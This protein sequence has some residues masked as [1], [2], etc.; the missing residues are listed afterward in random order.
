LPN[1]LVANVFLRSPVQIR[2]PHFRSDTT[3]HFLV[4]MDQLLG[5]NYPPPF[6]RNRFSLPPFFL[7][8]APPE[9]GRPAFM[10]VG[11]NGYYLTTAKA[12]PSHFLATVDFAELMAG[13]TFGNILVYDPV[14]E[15]L[16]T[17]ACPDWWD[18][19]V[20]F[21]ITRCTRGRTWCSGL[22]TRMA[23]PTSPR[24]MQACKPFRKASETGRRRTLTV[25]VW[26]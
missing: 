6:T 4:V 3:K 12:M 19:P 15:G 7:A 13:V 8:L 25:G 17:I 9:L 2:T 26:T 5:E 24:Q 14:P 10:R 18:Q 16:P 1:R 11:V 22:P 23:V 20:F 21:A